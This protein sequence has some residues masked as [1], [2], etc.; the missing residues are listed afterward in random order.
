MSLKGRVCSILVLLAVCCVT[1][2]EQKK[3]LV[4]S[5]PEAA[6]FSG[7]LMKPDAGLLFTALEKSGAASGKR[8]A[9]SSAEL[10]KKEAFDK[11]AY[12][13]LVVVGRKG[14]DPLLEQC[15]GH[16]AAIDSETKTFYRLGYGT[17][18]SDIGYVECDWN[19]FLYSN[20][21]RTNSFTTVI[22]K[23][24]GTSDAGVKAALDA[25]R[26][27]LLN[28][29]VPAGKVERVKTSILDRDPDPTP[30]PHLPQMVRAGERNAY[31]CGW[32]QPSEEEYRAFLD[33]AGVMPR[34]MWRVKYLADGALE[35][36]SARAWVNGLHRLAYGNTVMIAEFANAPD[37]EKTFLALS[38]V[39]G[40]KRGMTGSFDSVTFDQPRDE[41][42]DKSYG[43]IRYLR[44]GVFLYAVSLPESAIPAIMK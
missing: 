28:G 4:G 3:I 1:A 44:K 14:T 16:Q 8:E 22:V 5:C 43:K 11:A 24:S 21:V 38:R 35:D 27:G 26:K 39:R 9:V 18:R 13:H 42:F 29:V 7:G 10:L 20:K 33:A 37:A 15:W 19:P 40:A 25:F 34:R 2:G 17:L 23:I 36:V 31:L 41:A 30:P 6:E 12:N 32:T